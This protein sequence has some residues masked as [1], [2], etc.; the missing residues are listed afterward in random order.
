[1]RIE[2]LQW[3]DA[4]MA[5]VALHGVTPQD[6]EEVCFG[7]H[8]ARREAGQR[9]VLAGQSAAGKYLN[10]VVEQVGGGLFR[11]VTAF[12]MGDN[13]KRRYRRRLREVR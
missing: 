11:P 4:N 1:M 3:D 8:I 7:F 13:Y 5:H 2:S 6:V 9:Y 12:E 10:V